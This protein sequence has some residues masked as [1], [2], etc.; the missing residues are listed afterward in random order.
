MRG[1]AELATYI[2][3]HLNIKSVIV[4]GW[5]LGGHVGIEMIPLLA[6]RE[7]AFKGLMLTGTPPCLGLEQMDRGF[8]LADLHMSFA[9]KRDWPDE[10]ASEFARMAAGEPFEQWMED[11]A[12]RTDGRA[13]ELMLGK[14]AKG[15]GID[16]RKVVEENEEVL[17]AVVDGAVDPF[18]NLNY[19]EKIKW[20]NL[21]K[22]KCFRIPGLKHAPFWERP[23]V[24]HEY[25]ANFLIDCQGSK[26]TAEI[27]TER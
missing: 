6:E 7:I 8:S 25:L 22:G 1:Y 23:D 24:Y 17:I 4:L 9:G 19:V 12:K 15:V 2:L 26:S 21:W 20:K 18:I 3:E 10:V 13:R 5:S 14:L 27:F 16:Q 11:D